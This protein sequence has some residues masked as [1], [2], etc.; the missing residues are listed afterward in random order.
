MKASTRIPTLLTL[1]SLL[2]LLWACGTQSDLPPAT[3]EPATGFVFQV[4][5]A[6]E[7]VTL[8]E[9]P[10]LESPYASGYLPSDTRLL[11]PDEDIALRN[12]SYRFRRG[13]RF[14]MRLKVKNI[15]ETLEFEPPFFFTLNADTARIKSATAP[16][17]TDRDLGG[18]GC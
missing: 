13:H 3:V 15:T 16:L 7:S 18:T 1:L 6:Q 10:T 17:V 9:T 5:P 2:L 4:D 14:V 12:L 11:V 8:L